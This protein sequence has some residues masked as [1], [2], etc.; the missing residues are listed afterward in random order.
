MEGDHPSV[1]AMLPLPKHLPTLEQE[2]EQAMPGMSL[3][4]LGLIREAQ[5]T[6][7]CLL[8]SPLVGGPQLQRLP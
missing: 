5:A 2:R 8:L 1:Q 4:A 6:G 3:V 7:S